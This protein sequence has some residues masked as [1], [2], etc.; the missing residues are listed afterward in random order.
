MIRKAA[1]AGLLAVLI[2]LVGC[3]VGA[4]NTPE[5]GTG[6]GFVGGRSFTKVPVADRKAA[7]IVSGPELGGGKML[8][9]KDYAGKVIVLNV[10]GSWCPPCRAEAGDLEAASKETADVAIFLGL[11]VK[12]NN[13]APGVAFVR[14]QKIT[15]PSIFDPDGRTQVALA[16]ELPPKAIPSTLI[17]DKKGRVAARVLG[18]ISRITLVDLINEIAEES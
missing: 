17:I 18:E 13:E 7:P 1:V 4:G 16:G 10:W 8:S 9:T 6:E 3:S 14:T 15:Y 12:D 11:N 2:G 5:A